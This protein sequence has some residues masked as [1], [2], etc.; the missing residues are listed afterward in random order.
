MG[1]SVGEIAASAVAGALPPVEDALVVTRRAVL[2]RQVVM[3][4][5]AMI[6]VNKSTQDVIHDL[7]GCEDVVVSINSSPSSCVVAGAKDGVAMIAEKYKK[8]GIETFFVRTDVGFHSPMMVPLG[9][10]LISALRDTLNP[11]KPSVKLY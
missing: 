10:S 3:G 5:G 6:L 7:K 1:H 11:T 4:Q 2:Y 8:Q 9:D